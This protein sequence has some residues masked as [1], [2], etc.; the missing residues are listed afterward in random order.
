MRECVSQGSSLAV[1]ALNED[2][3][4][5]EPSFFRST[6]GTFGLNFEFHP[7]E[8]YSCR[9]IYDNRFFE[10]QPFKNVKSKSVS[11]QVRLFADFIPNEHDMSID[12]SIGLFV[13][14]LGSSAKQ[15]RR[16]ARLAPACRERGSGDNDNESSVR[17]ITLRA[18][19]A[20]TPE[21]VS[22]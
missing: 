1:R 5:R 9:P 21:R 10:E 6:E 22:R 20:I 16:I 4:L 3:V 12:T 18:N 19:Y 14:S 8:R 11:A 15:V 13:G 2:N 7:R 17:G